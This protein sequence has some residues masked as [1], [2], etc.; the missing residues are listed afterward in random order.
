MSEL[1]VVGFDDPAEADRVLLKLT[2]LKK[3]HLI[4]LED[5]VV[6]VRDANGKVQLK[7]S[8]NLV[9]MGAA[10]GGLSGGLWGALVGL[11][12]LN[13][14]AGFA[15][16]GA[17]GA[18]TGALSGSMMDYGIDDGFIKSLADTI[19]N[20]SSALFV[21]VRK[22][23][24]E[25]VLEELKGIHG[26]LLRTSLAPDQEQKL[27]DIIEQHV[28]QGTAPQGAVSPAAPAAAVTPS[29]ATAPQT[30]S[31]PA[32]APSPSVQQPPSA[33]AASPRAAPST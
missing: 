10:S 13:P 24:P 19:P 14:L 18:G 1:I 20:N 25:K 27:R 32:A 11:F 6:V 31:S 23:Q 8:I 7:Q 33:G 28:S 17:I 3:E 16:G 12:F 30:G 4:D 15:L 9:A 5:A 2:Q 29:P 21:L 22:A 26:R